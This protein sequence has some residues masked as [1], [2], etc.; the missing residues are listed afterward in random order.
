MEHLLPIV[1]RDMSRR[2]SNR[3][4]VSGF[5]EAQIGKCRPDMVTSLEERARLDEGK[6]AAKREAKRRATE[7]VMH[8][9]EPK[10]STEAIH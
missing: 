6:K 1:E 3:P 2:A 10:I 4:Q 5:T 9:L 8:E 7:G